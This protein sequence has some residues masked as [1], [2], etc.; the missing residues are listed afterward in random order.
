MARAGLFWCSA[1]IF[2]FYRQ[3][4][5]PTL[6]NAIKRICA[7]PDFDNGDFR[8]YR[9]RLV[10]RILTVCLFVTLILD[11]GTYLGDAVY[12]NALI[13]GVL[14]FAVLL[15]CKWI[16]KRGRLIL[17]E[18]ILTVVFFI[19]IILANISLG[20]IRAPFASFYVFWASMVGLLFGL[21]GIV[22]STVASSLAVMGL[23][24]AE[25]AGVLPKADFSVGLTQWITMTSI[26]GMTASLAYYTQLNTLKALTRAENEIA[27]RKLTEDRLRSSE[28][29]LRLLSENASDVIWTMEPDGSVSYISAAVE[30]VRGYTPEEAMRQPIDE[31]LLPE[32]L[33][34]SM[35]YFHKVVEAVQAGRPAERFRGELDYYRKDGTVFHAEVIAYPVLSSDG[36]LVQIVGVSRD[37]DERKQ[38]ELQLKQ[39]HDDLDHT[40]QALLVANAELNRLAETDALTGVWNRRHFELAARSGVALAKRQGKPLSMMMFDIDH[41]KVVNDNFGHL[42]GD[43]VLVALAELVRVNLRAGDVLARWGGE[44]F[45]VLLSDCAASDAVLLAEKLRALVAQ[46]PFPEVNQITISIGVAEMN[47]EDRRH[48][49]LNRVDTALYAAKAGGRNQVRLG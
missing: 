45:L 30:K 28:E 23:I 12:A 24:L 42:V 5:G 48:D 29:R 7:S 37:I 22:S 25:N 33:A 6:L 36:K 17:T 13:I 35:N 19:F 21:R 32:S 10:N 8:E 9:S 20:T 40:N 49:W 47:P 39:A 46:H 38:H 26:I 1:S 27:Q 3:F 41:F 11:V 43:R 2:S 44:E 34:I 18:V 16:L 14:W 31:A 15:F 4:A